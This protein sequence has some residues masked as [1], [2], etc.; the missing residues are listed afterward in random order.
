MQNHCVEAID[1]FDRIY[2]I[3]RWWSEAKRPEFQQK[4][5]NNKL[6]KVQEKNTIIPSHELM[7]IFT[8]SLEMN[9]M[10]ILTVYWLNK[11]KNPYLEDL[12]T[13]DERT[14]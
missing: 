3:A 7:I 6:L 11:R 1:E 12:I 4:L 13:F 8:D 10:C 9:F 5:K 14:E 2:R